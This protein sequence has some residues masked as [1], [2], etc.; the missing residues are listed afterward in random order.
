M[1]GSIVLELQAMASERKHDIADLLRKALIVATKLKLDDFK[2]WI[3]CELHGYGP[4]DKTPAY[5]AFT[6]KMQVHNPYRGLIPF[7][8]PPEIEETICNIDYRAAI[9]NAVGVLERQGSGNDKSDPLFELSS[10]QKT[11]LMRHMQD[12]MEPIRTVPAVQLDMV[13]DAVRTTI[14]EWSLKLEH[15]GIMG[16]GMTFSNEEKERAA[17]SQQIHIANF[18]GVLGDVANSHLTQNLIMNVKAGDFKSLADYLTS[19]GVGNADI[20]ELKDAINS[21]PKPEGGGKWGP[22]VSNWIGKM[23]TK[24]ASGV[25]EIGISA[26]SKVLPEAIATHYGITFL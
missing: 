3:N 18:Q 5:R 11:F 20:D 15:A 9:G 10:Q 22:K 14:L 23:I 19:N 26:A 4:D 16:D 25:W 6:A 7:L 2:Q 13:I 1:A 8:M 21:D 24:A 12:P 17:K